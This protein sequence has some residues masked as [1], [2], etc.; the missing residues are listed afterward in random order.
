M[1]KQWR[2]LP[3]PVETDP[4]LASLDALLPLLS[5]SGTA[6]PPIAARLL[7]QRG[8]HTPDAARSYLSPNWQEGIH[9]PGR[10]AQM[11]DAIA[12]M[13]RALEAGERVTVHGDYDADGVTGSAVLLGAVAEVQR[14]MA[15]AGKPSSSP[16]DFYIPHRDAEG[17]GLH[18]RTVDTLRERGTRLIVTVDCGIACA[19]EIAKAKS[20]G[21]DAIVV[22]HHQFGDELPAAALIH[23]R[24]P[25]E[26]YPF[27][28][29]A[30]VGVSWKFAVALLAEGRVRGLPIPEGWEKWLLDLVSI[31]TVTDMVPLVGENRVLERYGLTVLNKTR[32]PGLRALLEIAGIAPGA[33]TSRDVAFAIGPRL[34]AAGRMAHAELALRLLLAPDDAQA[35]VLAAELEGLNKDR[36]R[37]VAAMQKEAEKIADPSAPLIFFHSDQWSPALVG[38]VAGKWL[39]RTGRP[40]VAVGKHGDHWIGSGRSVAAYDITEAVKRAGEGLLTR[41]GGHVQAC[42][43]ALDRD[44]AVPEFRDR[45]I[46]DAKERLDLAKA[47]P[48]LDIDAELDPAEADSR[49]AAFLDTMEPFGEG[50]RRPVFAAFGLSLLSVD[51]M[52][53][54][55]KHVRLTVQS[56]AG[57]TGRLVGFNIADR[58]KEWRMGDRVDVAYDVSFNE[59]RGRKEPQCK[60]VDVRRP[61]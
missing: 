50:N 59:W 35:Q 11:S 51:T 55:G 47:V 52:G 44:D 5:D 18:T 42:G 38:L 26:T 32:R 60:I 34:N 29:L 1:E 14:A 40:S 20:F 28:H 22:D 25:G 30:A 48:T 13:F 21:I 61:A 16:V 15:A 53:A 41:A 54:T 3:D 10:F 45:L 33:A 24:L 9:D 39:D 6:P 58:F 36:Q 49:V 7:R 56:R 2:V 46:A 27:P 8:A 4:S 31:A 43:F 23:P 37:T 19:A 17:Y 57:R 12:R